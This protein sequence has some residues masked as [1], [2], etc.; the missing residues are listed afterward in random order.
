VTDEPT[1]RERFSLRRWSQ[2]KH[3][4]ARERAPADGALHS[5]RM[6]APPGS[7]AARAVEWPGRGTPAA[8]PAAAAS[9]AAVPPA[10]AAMSEAAVPLA[11]AAIAD[12]AARPAP[13]ATPNAADFLPTAQTPGPETQAALP[14]LDTLTIDS[15]YSVFMRPGVDDSVKCGALKKLFSDPRWNVMDGL[16]VYIDDYSKP[17]PIDPEVVRTLVSARYIFNPPATRVNALGHVEDVPDT[18]LQQASQDAVPTPATLEPAVP[19]HETAQHAGPQPEVARQ[20]P[21]QRD[22]LEVDAGASV[23]EA[24]PQ[25]V[26][27]DAVQ[28]DAPPVDAVQM[29]SAT[30]V[31]AASGATSNRR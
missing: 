4:A 12:P 14:P 8:L 30:D 10:P 24:S 13:A 27:A 15:D 21:P 18:P 16:D 11:P 28:H 20:A 3:D 25:H 17:D 6:S 23:P 5:D 29:S 9:G 19:E 2:R 22:A 7:D 1:D 31:T 26:P